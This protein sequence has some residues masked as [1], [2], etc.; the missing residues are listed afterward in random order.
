MTREE[1]LEAQASHTPVIYTGKG[2]MGRA[3]V[4]VERGRGVVARFR[5]SQQS[6]GVIVEVNRTKAI[7]HHE[8]ISRGRYPIADLLPANDDELAYARQ[9][10]C[11]HLPNLRFTY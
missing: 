3:C 4:V 2:S 6:L 10:N 1:A 11:E 8:G 5:G 9:Y 7:V